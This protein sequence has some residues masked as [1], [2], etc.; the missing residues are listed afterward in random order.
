LV[1]AASY[2]SAIH[3]WD[4]RLIRTR[5]RAMKLDWNWP[6][7]P[8][9]TASDTA[10]EPLTI[11]ITP[12][13]EVGNTL[14]AEQWTRLTIERLRRELVAN[15]DSVQACNNLAWTYLA[16]PEALR[17]VEAALPLAEKAARLS[18]GIATIRNTLGLAYYRAGRFRKA[19]EV[20][21]PNLESQENWVLA[22]DLYILAMSHCH[23]GELERARDYYDWAVRWSQVQRDLNADQ[24]RELLV[25]RVEAEELLGIGA[26]K[27]RVPGAGSQ[28]E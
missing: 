2:V 11:E 23:L 21:R 8:S 15:P 27:N 6:E 13:S 19:I 1:V 25:F 16:G 28:P 5:L 10:S 3:I 20:L 18:A 17:D 26:N 22:F 24:L 4:L 14:T 9:S 12:G 7:F